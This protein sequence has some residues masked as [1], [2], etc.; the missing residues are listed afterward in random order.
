MTPNT[1][2]RIRDL[3]YNLW[4]Q[5]GRPDGHDKEFW[6]RAERE[7]GEKEGLDI[8][9]EDAEIS[10]IPLPAGPPTH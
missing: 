10:P 9:D 6:Q 7:L 5:A 8:S 2:D 4:E 1:E 3:A